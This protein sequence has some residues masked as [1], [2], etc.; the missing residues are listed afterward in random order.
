MIKELIFFIIVI[1]LFFIYFVL[2]FYDELLQKDTVVIKFST[3]FLRKF[4]FIKKKLVAYNFPIIIN[5][6]L[7]VVAGKFIRNLSVFNPNFNI[8]INLFKRPGIR[9]RL[10]LLSLIYNLIVC[11]LFNCFNWALDW[12]T[13]EAD[14]IHTNFFPKEYLGLHIKKASFFM[15]MLVTSEFLLLLIIISF[16]WWMFEYVILIPVNLCILIVFFYCFLFCFFCKFFTYLFI[17]IFNLYISK[18]SIY[19]FK[20]NFMNFYNN[21]WYRIRFIVWERSSIFIKIFVCIYIFITF[22]LFFTLL[23]I[24]IY[25]IIFF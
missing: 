9:L 19:Y 24:Y 17:Y 2:I 18:F 11:F 21:L 7:Y 13:L 4:N 6:D 12:H 22:N 5:I 15:F 1:S 23:Y 14:L 16:I 20:V 25:D 10:F 3:K 8:R